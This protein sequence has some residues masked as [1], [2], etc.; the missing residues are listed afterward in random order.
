MSCSFA[1]VFISTVFRNE[2]EIIIII[3]KH[4]SETTV[5]HRNYVTCSLETT[6]SYGNDQN[7]RLFN[8]LGN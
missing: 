8:T 6:T 5:S 4:I 3:I 7:P 1:L 2:R